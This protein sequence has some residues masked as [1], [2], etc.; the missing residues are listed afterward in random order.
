M[1]THM[2]EKMDQQY[3]SLYYGEI[4]LVPVQTG[5]Y[6]Y[7]SDAYKDSWHVPGRQIATTEA[8]VKLA[9]KHG[10]T[11]RV[12]ESSRDGQAMFRLN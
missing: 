6:P 12:V 3:R 5:V 4:R 2:T 8:L 9:D 1:T 7:L 10:I 11:V